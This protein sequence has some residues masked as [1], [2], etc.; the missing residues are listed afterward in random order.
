MGTTND[1]SHVV[2]CEIG[3]QRIVVRDAAHE[4]DAVYDWVFHS[5]SELVE[6]VVAGGDVK[7]GSPTEVTDEVGQDCGFGIVAPASV[8]D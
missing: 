5:S 6:V 1:L 3:P 7:V 8:P 4:I 2:V